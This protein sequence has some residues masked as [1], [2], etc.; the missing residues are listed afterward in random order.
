MAVASPFQHERWT[1]GNNPV[2]EMPGWKPGWVHLSQAS[3]A[4]IDPASLLV[5]RAP[6]PTT[7]RLREELC[8]VEGRDWLLQRDGGVL[9]FT[10]RLGK[11]PTALACH[12]PG[13]GPLWITGPLVTQNVWQSWCEKTWLGID[14]CAAS[15]ME[16]LEGRKT[17]DVIFVHHGNAWELRNYFTQNKAARLIVDEIHRLS[18]RRQAKQA[19]GVALMTRGARHRIGLTG[20][21]LW[22]GV[23]SLWGPL[24]IV[25]PEAWGSKH[26]FGVRYCD[27]MSNGFGWTYAGTSNVE[28]L[29]ERLKHV[30]L[31]RTWKRDVAGGLKL[32]R[33]VELLDISTERYPLL[34]AR[35]AGIADLAAFRVQLGLAKAESCLNYLR[36]L[37]DAIVWVWH[38]EVGQ[39]V[40]KGLGKDR[41]IFVHGKQNEKKRHELMEKWRQCGGLLVLTIASCSEGVDLSARGVESVFVELDYTP[42]V[43][44]QAEMRGY[45]IDR[46]SSVV[47]LVAKPHDDF[48]LRHVERKGLAEEA[49]F[50]DATIP[51]STFE[52]VGSSVVD[53]DGA[54]D[55]I[56]SSLTEMLI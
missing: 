26:D 2:R 54:A 23:H 46:E 38:H 12:D 56:L 11:T 33:S 6:P 24:S 48:V 21:P 13:E 34:R 53:M 16:D 50:Y 55:W 18:N 30:L 51:P 49:L 31:R 29:R 44:G 32:K 8:Q 17:P 43:L 39:A 14:F 37:G 27:G 7:I 1:R 28:E 20:T 52:G 3:Q 42:T 40:V 25:N 9:A 19:D 45:T 15:G 41:C 5:E 10:Q 4:G 47:Y 35:Q 36:G 22:N